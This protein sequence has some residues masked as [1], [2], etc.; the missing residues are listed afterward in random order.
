MI[1]LIFRFLMIV[2]FAIVI[3]TIAEIMMLLFEIEAGTIL[4]LFTV[5]L[6]VGMRIGNKLPRKDH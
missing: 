4:L 2:G 6:F 1:D 5:T 3:T